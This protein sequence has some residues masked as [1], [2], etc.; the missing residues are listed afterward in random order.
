MRARLSYA[1]V[2]AA[3]VSMTG[4]GSAQIPDTV[5]VRIGGSAQVVVRLVPTR[6][7]LYLLVESTAPTSEEAVS[8]TARAST[9]V[10]DTLRRAGGADDLSLVEYG[11]VPTPVNYPT[12]AAN[13]RNGYT[14]RAAVRFV[15]SLAR[16][17]ALTSAAYARGASASA[18]PQFQHEGVD[19]AIARAIEQATVLARLRAESIA[20]GLGGRL[21]ALIGIDSHPAYN[22]YSQPA[23]FP[24]PQGYDHQ[25][26]PVPEI[27]HTVNVNGSWVFVP[28]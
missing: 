2:V 23:T 16:V 18:A 8:Q 10:M 9:G 28:R 20:R 17:Q 14:S 12:P 7:V 26:R 22:E 4:T 27:K 5:R 15:A 6:A 24:P 25:P 11:V 19:T 1:A 3:M 13:Q 21:G